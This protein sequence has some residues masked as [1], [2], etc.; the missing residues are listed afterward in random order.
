MKMRKKWE[1]KILPCTAIVLCATL[2]C[3]TAVYALTTGENPLKQEENEANTEAGITTA[4]TST[5][6]ADADGDGQDETVYVLSDA[7]GAVQEIIVS[8]WLTDAMGTSTYYQEEESIE[9]ELPVT[10]SVSY[11]LDG[12][13]ISPS[14]LCGQSGHVTMRYDYT[15]TQYET[16][17]IRGQT[18]QIYIPFVMLTG[19]ILDNESFTNVEVTNGKLVNDGDHTVVV[20]LALPGMQESLDL[21]P[22]ELELPGYVEISADVSNFE[23]GMT[24]TIA[25]NELAREV[26]PEDLNFT[27]DLDRS[28]LELTDAMEQLM[29]GSSQ[30]YEGLC[31]LQD[32]S[33]DLVSGVDL[34]E[35]GAGSLA[36]GAA[37]L[38]SGAGQLQSGMNELK[39]GLDTLQSN[40]GSL[41]Q[42]AGQVFDSLLSMANS[43][44]AS[45]GLSVSTLTISNYAEVLNGVISSLD[46]TAVYHQALS[47]VTAAVEGQR[48]AIQSQVAAAVEQEIKAQVTAAVEEQVRGQ[49]VPAVKEQLTPQVEAA[50]KAQVSAQTEEA[51]IQQVTEQVTG[52]AMDKAAYEAAVKE[53]AITAEV[54][55]AVTNAVESAVEQQLASEDTRQLMADALEEQMDSADVQALIASQ[56][57]T[58]MAADDIQKTISDT[59]AEKLASEDIQASIAENTELQVQKAISENMSGETVQSQLAAASAGAQSVISLKASLDS[60]HA[61]Y[62][63]LQSYT[64]GVASA[65]EGAA[66]LKSGV[67]SLADGAGQLKSGAD[68]L[69]SGIQSMQDS[70]PAL[71]DGISQL[72]DGAGELAE[73]LSEFN[74]EGIQKLVDAVDGDLKG[75]TERM[76][77]VIQV[78]RN[79]RSF[80]SLPVD[81]GGK[82]TFIYKTAEIEK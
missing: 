36:E 24:L 50:V 46:E 34:L 42:G 77:A 57:E 53:G 70:I 65:A 44:L 62:L 59:T 58:A 51:A 56:T 8:D 43:Q 71:L 82:I 67:D 9:K 1:A 79:Y 18:E 69:H 73:G 48:S 26:D 20:G 61:F 75:L 80:S 3:G 39:N 5:G 31:T 33:D 13:D 10:L 23:L 22:E 47:Q 45:A 76:Q 32:S 74:E 12:K 49:I 37:S 64:S 54:Q 41:N 29:D 16:R 38:N 21:D 19:M 17:V 15:N 66:Q 35:E 4:P 14:E 63:G 25:S 2:V 78:G 68:S 7:S 60:Y 55:A 27:E 28:L 11:W 72:C 40:S 6:T 30:L 81:M 52:T